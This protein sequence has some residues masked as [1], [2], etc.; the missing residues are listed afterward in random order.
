MQRPS[1]LLALPPPLPL[2]LHELPSRRGVGGRGAVGVGLSI[3]L[4]R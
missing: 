4:I 1:A 3:E 2:L